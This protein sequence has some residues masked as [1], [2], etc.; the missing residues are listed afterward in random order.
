MGLPG[1][2]LSPV[3]LGASGHEGSWHRCPCSKT[4]SQLPCQPSEDAGPCL[5]ERWGPLDFAGISN[6]I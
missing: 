5:L 6:A 1:P 3:A 2:P 4:R